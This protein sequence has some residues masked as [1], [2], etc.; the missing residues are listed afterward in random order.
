MQSEIKKLS[1]CEIYTLVCH[2]KRHKCLWMRNTSSYVNPRQRYRA[3]RKIQKNIAK[4]G[5]TLLEVIAM[6]SKVRKSYLSQLRKIIKSNLCTLKKS[7]TIV[8]KWFDKIHDFLYPYLNY[9]ELYRL[10]KDIEMDNIVKRDCLGKRDIIKN[11]SKKNLTYPTS[12][13]GQYFD[14]SSSRNTAAAASQIAFSSS[15]SIISGITEDFNCTKLT[16][17]TSNKPQHNQQRQLSES[18]VCK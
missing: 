17:H 6:L 11:K 12:C 1:D 7:Q 15:K 9:D 18:K 16:L 4:P 3:Y 14:V 10:Y 5:M 2:Y 13:S 8:P